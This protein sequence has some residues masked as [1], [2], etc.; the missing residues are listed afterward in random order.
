[1]SIILSY[2]IKK[3]L[4]FLTLFDIVFNFFSNLGAMG[5]KTH[6]L[7]PSIRGSIF[8]RHFFS[9]GDIFL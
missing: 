4:N 2:V 9:L 3:Y 6:W 1:M 7:S 8:T 5:P